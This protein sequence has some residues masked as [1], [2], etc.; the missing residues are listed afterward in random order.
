MEYEDILLGKRKDFSSVYMGKNASQ[1]NIKSILKFAFEELLGWTPETVRDYTDHNLI[2]AL[3]LERPVKKLYFPPEVSRE[4]DLFYLA[5]IL[6]PETIH[7]SKKELILKVYQEVLDGKIA[8]YPKNFFTSSDGKLTACTCL[9][10]ALKQFLN[11]TSIDE[12]YAYFAD[13]TQ[14]NAFLKRVRLKVP[15][16]DIYEYPIDMLHDSLP[17]TQRDELCYRF[18]RFLAEMKDFK[19]KEVK[20][21]ENKD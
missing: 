16:D 7:F 1:T 17:E 2:K 13:R 11:I 21:N 18:E 3:H 5:G 4:T 14:A 6:Y 20:K 15:C 19:E 10:Y 12:L 8:K 9:Y